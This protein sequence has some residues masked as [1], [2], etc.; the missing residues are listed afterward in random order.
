MQSDTCHMMKTCK[1]GNVKY[2]DKVRDHS[3]VIGKSPGEPSV[4]E[5]TKIINCK[6]KVDLISS[7]RV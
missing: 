4:N 6:T 3:L 2:H 7:Q 1:K 5:S